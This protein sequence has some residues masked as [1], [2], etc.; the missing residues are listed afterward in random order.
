M[1]ICITSLS[2]DTFGGAERVIVS[3]ATHFAE[4]GHEVHILTDSF[5]REVLSNYGE[6]DSINVHQYPINEGGTVSTH[7]SHARHIRELLKSIKPDAVIAHYREKETWLA[8][9]TISISPVFATHVHGSLFWFENKTNRTAHMWK[10]CTKD[11]ISDVPGHSEFWSVSSISLSERLQKFSE[12]KIEALA[13]QS[14]DTVFVNTYQV[15]RELECLYGVSPIVNPPGVSDVS[16]E[17]ELTNEVPVDQPFIFSVSRLDA[18]KRIDLLLRTFAELLNFRQNIRLVIGGTGDE[19][20]HLK[21][22]AS[23]LNIRENVVFAGYI[24]EQILSSYYSEAEVFACPG[25]MSY[26]LTPLEAVRSGTKVA[27]STD[28]FAK[29]VIGN[30][31]GVKVIA[32]KLDAWVSGL[33]KLIGYDKTPS[34]THVPTTKTHAESKLNEILGCE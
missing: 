30:K 12:E 16:V 27:L 5:D 32:P 18:R 11:I 7:L 15:A 28:A 24:N 4:A 25:W 14:C 19:E 31:D 1:R 3:D 13:L 21:N 23:D 34:S 10:D 6:L 26:G 8:L 33:V 2:L 22:L 20:R 9:S 17:K 29:E